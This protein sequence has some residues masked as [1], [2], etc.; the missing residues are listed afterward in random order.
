MNGALLRVWMIFPTG[1]Q[2]LTTAEGI[3]NTD[4]SVWMEGAEW[5]SHPNWSRKPRN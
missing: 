1:Y 4:Q 3:V 2:E 5:P